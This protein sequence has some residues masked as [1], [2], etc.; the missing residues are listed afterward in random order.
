MRLH[1]R[2]IKV[3]GY[4]ALH[5]GGRGGHFAPKRSVC[6]SPRI[7]IVA[8]EQ[9]TRGRLGADGFG[10]HL[11]GEL[12]IAEPPS[13]RSMAHR[14]VTRSPY[15]VHVR[16]TSSFHRV[17]RSRSTDRPRWMRVDSGRVV[18]LDGHAHGGESH[19]RERRRRAGCEW[20]Y[21]SA[22]ISPGS[23]GIR[24]DPR[25]GSPDARQLDRCRQRRRKREETACGPNCSTTEHKGVPEGIEST[26][27]LVVRS[28][29][30]TANTGGDGGGAMMTPTVREYPGAVPRGESVR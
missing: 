23:R 3:I 12:F 30:V 22:N 15:P 18:G 11:D 6:D 14:A 29:T 20:R 19:H 1:R 4:G 21:A 13:P 9:R 25:A 2:I 26:A 24:R 16:A 10:H 7:R 27:S 17:S 28:S 8:N 5:G